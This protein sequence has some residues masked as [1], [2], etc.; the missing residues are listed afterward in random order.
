MNARTTISAFALVTASAVG[1]GFAIANQAAPAK[2][3][4]QAKP[5][6][7]AKAGFKAAGGYSI[8]G[9]HSTVI[10][11]IKHMNTSWAFGRF[12]R[13]SGTFDLLPD[14]MER[15]SLV[16]SIETASVD[17]NEP[18]RDGH[19][20]SDAFLDVEQFPDATFVSK[21]IKPA[22][23]G[24]YSV[25]GSLSLHGVKKLLTVTL[26]ETGTS[27]TPRTGVRAGF[28][29]TFTIKRSDFGIKFMPEALGDEIQLTV[30]IEGSQTDAPKK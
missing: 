11:K 22:G 4:A 29:G 18:K 23:E 10:F 7:P 3:A 1:A 24:K 12:D 30:S 17:T 21:S 20:K 28:F 26:E 6:E 19:L 15:S 25:E 13:I 2:A 8:D 14:N 5:A 9:V 16:V 27:D